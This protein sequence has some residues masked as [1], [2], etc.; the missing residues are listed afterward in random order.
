MQKAIIT[1]LLT[2]VAVSAWSDFSC[3]EATEPA[4][5]DKGDKVCPATARCVD[6]SAVCFDSF[7]CD[8]SEGFVCESRYDALMK[9]CRE[10]AQEH[11]ALAK[12]NVDLR[13]QRL[14]WKNCV[15]NADTL[16][17]ARQCVR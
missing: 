13:E 8:A 5:L 11:N 17:G 1:A 2:L 7:P 14:A 9:D 6:S 4:C 3:P 10:A 12:Q 15:L 16:A